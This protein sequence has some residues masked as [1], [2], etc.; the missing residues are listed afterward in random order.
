METPYAIESEE[1]IRLFPQQLGQMKAQA[2]KEGADT[3]VWL[4]YCNERMI[5]HSLYIGDNN[6]H[7]ICSKEITSYVSEVVS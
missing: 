2:I 6:P 3:I 4:E 7:E 1:K 5:E